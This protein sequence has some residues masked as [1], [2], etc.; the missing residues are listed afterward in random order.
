MK[1]KRRKTPSK[2]GIPSALPALKRAAKA[3]WRLS[4]ATNT[5]FY[6][7]KNGRVVNLNRSAKVNKPR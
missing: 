6:V 4:V 2:D 7:V 3:A 1:T 5:P